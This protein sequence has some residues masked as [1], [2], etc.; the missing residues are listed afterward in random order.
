MSVDGILGA[1]IE[2]RDPDACVGGD[3]RRAIEALGREGFEN[4]RKSIP[5][6]RDPAIWKD[7]GTSGGREEDFATF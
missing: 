3:A 5:R 1:D 2:G 7:G 6:L 4:S